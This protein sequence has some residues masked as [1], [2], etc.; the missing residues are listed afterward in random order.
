MKCFLRSNTP[1][2]TLLHRAA[3]G[4]RRTRPEAPRFAGTEI[5]RPSSPRS[6]QSR[7]QLVRSSSTGRPKHR[8]NLLWRS[9]TAS[10]RPYRPLVQPRPQRA[11]VR[12][13]RSQTPVPIVFADALP[14]SALECDPVWNSSA[15]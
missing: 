15:R 6:R 1:L 9:P 10:D 12:R 7:F 14:A 11:S 5:G 3:T 8:R 13:G 4:P 2:A